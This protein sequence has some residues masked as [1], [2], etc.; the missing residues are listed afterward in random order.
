M[1][2]TYDTDIPLIQTCDNCTYCNV[3]MVS[4]PNET[5]ALTN[6]EMTENLKTYN[7]T[8]DADY[9]EP[10]GQYTWCYDC[11]NSEE[12]LTGCID[13]DVTYTGH[14]LTSAMATTYIVLL[15]IVIF[16]IVSSV[17]LYRQLPSD[18]M[19]D[20]AGRIIQISWLKYFRPVA[21]GMIY[22]F[23]FSLLF[24][25]SNI[26]TAYLPTSMFANFLFML[27]MLMGWLGVPMVIIILIRIFEGI[28]VDNK[29]LRQIERGI[30]VE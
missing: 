12:A 22:V 11:G 29:M 21:G 4:W 28:L 18:N 14:E 7:Y 16:M 19:R 10:I 25:A 27:A 3:T 20:D 23:M 17:I 24:L 26:A 30:D 6:Q 8:L 13:F 5:I 9:T 2:Y 1:A 15:L